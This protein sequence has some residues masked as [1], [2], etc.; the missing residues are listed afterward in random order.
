V[1]LTAAMRP[2]SATLSDGPENL[3]QAFALALHPG[4]QGVMVAMNGHIWAGHEVRKAH[5]WRLDAFNAGDA[6]PLGHIVHLGSE[7][8]VRLLRPWPVAPAFIAQA[9]QEQMKNG[10]KPQDW[11]VVELVHSHAQAHAQVVHALLKARQA[12]MPLDGLVV[13]ATGSGTL[14]AALQDGLMQAQA[15]GVLVWVA[16]RVAAGG[17]L[18]A[19]GHAPFPHT[20]ACTPAQARVALVVHLMQQWACGPGWPERTFTP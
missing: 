2:A 12:G 11:P 4:A 5:T 8:V 16:S 7:R 10:L 14:H 6:G 1:V 9:L 18:P 17:C 20:G 19:P 3:W 13:A 15:Q